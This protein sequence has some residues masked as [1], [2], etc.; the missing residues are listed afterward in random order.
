MDLI[1]QA[2]QA[3]ALSQQ[4]SFVLENKM[5]RVEGRLWTHFAKTC[6][7]LHAVPCWDTDKGH[8]HQ[9]VSREAQRS[10][11]EVT[12]INSEV[13]EQLLCSLPG[14]HQGSLAPSVY[15]SH[16]VSLCHCISVLSI[17]LNFLP[18][19]FSLYASFIVVSLL[20]LATSLLLILPV[21]KNVYHLW[22]PAILCCSF[23]LLSFTL[24]TV[25]KLFP[26]L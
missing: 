15:F 25:M 22:M 21:S 12:D 14:V 9:T 8:Y 24:L 6:H 4:A 19:F 17:F 26:L 16:C 7:S 1:D 10:W 2:R 20:I 11:E 3:L 18:F 23:C 13:V 5:E